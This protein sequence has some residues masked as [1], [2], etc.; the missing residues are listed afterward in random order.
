MSKKTKERK[1]NDQ[2]SDV[3]NPNN[4]DYKKDKKNTKKQNKKTK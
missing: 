1:P 2:K 4:A 3:K